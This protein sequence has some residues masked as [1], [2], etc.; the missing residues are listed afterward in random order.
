M[1][2]EW[3]YYVTNKQNEKKNKK[4]DKHKDG[5]S[6]VDAMIW[7]PMKRLYI[8]TERIL[9]LSKSIKHRPGIIILSLFLIYGMYSSSNLGGYLMFGCCWHPLTFSSLLII[10]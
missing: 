4:W 10:H 3:K 6:A 5:N 8:Y 1:K 7:K 9:L 2:K